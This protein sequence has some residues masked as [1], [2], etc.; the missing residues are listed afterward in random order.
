MQYKD[1]KIKI[2]FPKEIEK[3]VNLQCNM[4]Y[5]LYANFPE[6]VHIKQL[7]KQINPKNVLDIGCGIGRASIFLFK[8]Y[9]WNNT[10]FYLLDG[11]YGN[12]QIY[13]INYNKEYGYYNS[14]KHTKLFCT[15]N[16][17]KKYK[18]INADNID[19]SKLPKF[20]LVYS[21][22][23]IGYHFEMSLYLNSWL[24][25]YLSNDAILIFG[26]R[27]KEHYK[28]NKY[29]IEQINTNIFEIVEIYESPNNKI[30]KD[31]VIILKYKGNK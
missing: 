16:G 2:I 10:I 1:T 26:I 22:L 14:L 30:S 20:D 17:L 5:N 31:S 27:G 8:Y 25:S 23:A 3:Y 9:N 29:Q 18:I 19:K 6:L 4:K 11:N 7:L 24:P 28:W 15:A 21:F 13:G 12:N